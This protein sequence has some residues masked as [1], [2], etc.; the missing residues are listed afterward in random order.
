[1]SFW[2]FPPVLFNKTPLT[3]FL[4]FSFQTMNQFV[5]VKGVKSAVRAIESCY[6]HIHLHQIS[7]LGLRPWS[8][9]G[10][11]GLNNNQN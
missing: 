8:S 6:Y 9:A 3:S 2:F 7:H 10:G 4:L 1:M 5:S 11:E